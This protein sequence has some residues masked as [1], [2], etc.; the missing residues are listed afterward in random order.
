MYEAIQ[1]YTTFAN[2][3]TLKTNERGMIAPGFIADFTAFSEDFYRDPETLKKAHV[4][5]TIINDTIVYQR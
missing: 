1:L 3:P 4:T 5:H 2:I